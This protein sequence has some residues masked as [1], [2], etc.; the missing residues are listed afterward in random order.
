VGSNMV[1][2]EATDL[3]KLLCLGCATVS[4]CLY[5]LIFRV[6]NFLYVNSQKT[7]PHFITDFFFVNR[8]FLGILA[9]G[10]RCIHLV[11]KQLFA[12]LVT[13]LTLILVERVRVRTVSLSSSYILQLASVS[14]LLEARTASTHSKASLSGSIVPH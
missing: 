5:Y 6:A 13:V 3:M 8:H 2:L 7:Q 1:T 11:L 4:F 12:T 14:L 9:S 10:T